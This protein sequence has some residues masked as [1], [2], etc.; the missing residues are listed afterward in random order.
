MGQKGIESEDHKNA[1]HGFSQDFLNIR[2]QSIP[3]R[4]YF[5]LVRKYTIRF[6][7]VYLKKTVNKEK[8]IF[9]GVT[10]EIVG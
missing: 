1:D 9:A 10:L 7:V 5:Q 6:V 2:F 3:D 8:E 4:F